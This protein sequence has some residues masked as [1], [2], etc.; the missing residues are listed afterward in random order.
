MASNHVTVTAPEHL[1]SLLSADL[2]RVS[3]LYFRADWAEPCV[4]MDQVVKELAKRWEQVLFLSVSSK[5]T[6]LGQRLHSYSANSTRNDDHDQIEAEALPD[7][8]ESFE[9][10]AVPYFVLLRVSL[11][12][13]QELSFRRRFRSAD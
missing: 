4:Q 2:S 9:V 7:I 6:C 3:C 1:Q 8:S 11:C 13:S 5:P 12:Y 10:D